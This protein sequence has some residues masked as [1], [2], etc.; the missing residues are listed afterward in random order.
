MIN[1][2][3]LETPYGIVE[4]VEIVDENGNA[5]QMTKAHYE[6]QQAEQSTPSLTDE[7]ETK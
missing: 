5:T 3:T 6:S 4:L 7:A 1:E 2:I